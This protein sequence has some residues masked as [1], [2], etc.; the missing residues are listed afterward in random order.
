MNGY[1]APMWEFTLNWSIRYSDLEV[2]LGHLTFAKIVDPSSFVGDEDDAA[3]EDIIR[4]V[5]LVGDW[6]KVLPILVNQIALPDHFGSDRG[7]IRDFAVP[8]YQEASFWLSDGCPEI[9]ASWGLRAKGFGQM[10]IG[11][12]GGH[13]TAGSDP[14]SKDTIY[15]V[16]KTIALS[17]NLNVIATP[18]R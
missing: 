13:V 12:A 8:A 16:L 14:M 2:D 9:Y 18:L 4:P 10:S 7:T 6:A 17:G 11:F 1:F 15:H 3:D 5:E